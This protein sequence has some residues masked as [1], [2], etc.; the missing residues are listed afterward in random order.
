MCCVWWGWAGFEPP[1]EC[2]GSLVAVDAQR[3][4]VQPPAKRPTLARHA[5]FSQPFRG[6]AELSG[7]FA[8]YLVLGLGLLF[9]GKQEAVEATVEVAKTL[10]ERVSKCG[11]RS[12]SPAPRRA[13]AA[14]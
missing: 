2:G 13:R 7:P 8:K 1:N 12:P 3:P 14:V 9:L 6:D 10:S 4:S 11:A 5:C